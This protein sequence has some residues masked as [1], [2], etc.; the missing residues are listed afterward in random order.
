MMREAPLEP[1]AMG[2]V[3]A[4]DGW[5]VVNVRDAAWVTSESFG[6]A[7]IVEGDAAPFA[8]LGLTL[9]VLE[10]GQPS[11]LYH[12]ESNQED[13]LVLAG[14][15]L[16]I[17]EGQERRLRAWDLVHCPAGTE[18]IFVG[19]G[20]SRCLIFMVGSRRHDKR[21]TYPRNEIAARHHAGAHEATTSPA[22][23]YAPFA[24]WRP[25]RPRGWSSLPWA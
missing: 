22:Q 15:C 6:G 16:L 12:E 13:F 3:A 25:G 2:L 21:I 23:A 17:V 10:P 20:E 8:D 19:A 7:C 14:E 18:H 1:S 4:S 9:A 11:G 5:F 24:P